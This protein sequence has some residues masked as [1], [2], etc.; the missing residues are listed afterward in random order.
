MLLYVAYLGAVFLLPQGILEG[1]LPRVTEEE[2]LGT[3]RVIQVYKMTGSKKATI[4]GSL[5]EEGQMLRNAT[6]KVIRG[7]EVRPGL[8][9]N[10]K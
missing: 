5:V 4:G 10:I 2:V 7:G 9:F 6:F 3:A 8:K 1:L